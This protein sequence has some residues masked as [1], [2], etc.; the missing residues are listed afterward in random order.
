MLL[1]TQGLVLHTT[2]YSESSVIAKIF[3]RQLGLRSYILKGVRSAAGRT[4]LNLLQPMS[5]LDLVVYNNPKSQINYIKEISSAAPITAFDTDPVSSALRFFMAEL[6]YKSLREEEPLPVLFDYCVSQLSSAQCQV[7]SAGV[8]VSSLPLL[9]QLTVLR[10]LGLEPLDNYSIN[11]P[12]FN[13]K[14]GRYMASPSPYAAAV[15]PNVDYL[16]DATS[17]LHLHHYLDALNSQQPC[18]LL[19]LQQRT[20]LINVLLEYYR[21]HIADFRNFKSHEILHAVLS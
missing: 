18:P 12:L 5:F 19:T 16:L 11:E 9:F 20:T 21:I 10:H 17:S 3:T 6:L 13:L 4:K 2:N 15:D 14:E 1:S 8:Q 7:S